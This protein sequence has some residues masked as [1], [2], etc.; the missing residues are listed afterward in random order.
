VS[1]EEQD[2]TENL[3]LIHSS[4][5]VET[6]PEAE[7]SKSVSRIELG[8]KP[9]LFCFAV[10]LNGEP[11][12]GS[13]TKSEE[14][15]TVLGF[16]GIVRVPEIFYLF[17]DDY[18]GKGYAFEAV[19]AFLNDYWQRFPLGLPGI[20][21]IHRDILEGHV[22]DGNS[23]SIKLLGKLGFYHVRGSTGTG[24][25]RQDYPTKVFQLGRPVA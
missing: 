6:E 22:L 7:K 21:P 23:A 16:L 13:H 4:T 1:R 5:G 24:F 20:D 12:N 10:E 9:G 3:L 18:W 25:G 11:T 17:S 19:T 8:L 14:E 2:P 15:T